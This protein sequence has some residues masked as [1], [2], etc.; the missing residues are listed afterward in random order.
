[1]PG[2]YATAA[3]MKNVV[4]AVTDHLVLSAETTDVEQQKLDHV[5]SCFGGSFPMGPASSLTPE[6]VHQALNRA[7]PHLLLSQSFFPLLKKGAS[8]SFTFITG[9][10]G[11]RCSMPGVAA[12]TI[13]NAAIYGMIRAIEAEQREQ[14]QRQPQKINEIR[15]GA[16]IRRDSQP[17]HP[18][19]KEGRAYPASLIGDVAVRLAM[20]DQRGDDGIFRIFAADLEKQLD[21]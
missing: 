1:M 3:T 17:G 21:S 16:L 7:L 9:A 6:S 19:I 5:V 4:D 15:I 2:D 13:A 14:Q 11:E 18:F 12:L 8:S 10:L 20:T